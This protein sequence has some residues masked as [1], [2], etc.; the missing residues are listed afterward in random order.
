MFPDTLDDRVTNI[1]TSFTQSSQIRA[2]LRLQQESGA[3]YSVWGPL[4]S[5]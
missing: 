5:G 1:H 3:V 4:N 2:P